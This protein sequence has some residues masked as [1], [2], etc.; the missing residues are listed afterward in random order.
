MNTTFLMR[1]WE[2]IDTLLS[3]TSLK[4]KVRA[5]GTQFWHRRCGR[6]NIVDVE[7]NKNKL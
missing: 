2:S 4:T 5:I 7:L 1:N 3:I 6:L